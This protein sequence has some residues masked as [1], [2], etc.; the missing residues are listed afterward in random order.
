MSVKVQVMVVEATLVPTLYRL[1]GISFVEVLGIPISD[2]H[3]SLPLLTLSH[4][5]GPDKVIRKLG[6]LQGCVGEGEDEGIQNTMT[7]MD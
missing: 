5:A 6:T 3:T 1:H 4:T 2:P 7:C